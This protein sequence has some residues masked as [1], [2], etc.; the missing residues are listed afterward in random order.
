VGSSPTTFARRKEP[1]SLIGKALDCSK[2]ELGSNPSIGSMRGRLINQAVSLPRTHFRK[3]CLSLWIDAKYANLLGSRLDRFKVEKHSPYSAIFRCP[4][5]GDSK[6]NE[7][8]RRGNL[9]SSRQALWMKCF[10]CSVS[11]PFSKFLKRIDPILYSEYVIETFKDGEPH[12]Q[13]QPT[14]TVRHGPSLGEDVMDR[15]QRIG[16]LSQSHPARVYLE[17]RLVRS[18]QFTRVYYTENYA[19]FVNSLIPEKLSKTLADP[20][21]IFPF[22]RRDGKTVGFQGRT[23]EPTGIRY[24]SVMLEEDTKMFGLDKNN[25]TKLTYVFEGP[26]DS[27]F[28]DN[29][30]A[31]AGSDGSLNYSEFSRIVFA[32][33][34]E[35]RN[36]PIVERMQKTI[37]KGHS[38]VIWP[39]WIQEK[40]ANDMVMA[41]MSVFN[42]EKIMAEHTYHG[43]SASSR[44]LEWKK[45]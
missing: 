8:K 1:C 29:A 37:E 45:V 22:R 41:G 13:T 26:I 27:L 7:Y 16:D 44:L 34:N 40:D 6:K 36:K 35:P 9:F 31:M 19:E 12:K 28:V 10:N 24:V 33:D 43:L 20:R 39:E 15:L 5:C 25:P 42:L 32:Y 30:I 3:R 38:L 14:P 11:M 17:K 18:H 21:I 23:L 2:E 4:I